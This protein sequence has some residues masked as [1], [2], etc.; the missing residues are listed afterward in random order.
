VKRE[1]LV[2]TA[3]IMVSLALGTGCQKK[4]TSPVQQVDQPA[5]LGDVTPAPEGTTDMGTDVAV[6][7]PSTPSAMP[8]GTTG[9]GRIHV[10]QRGDTLFKLAR[11]YYN[12]QSQWKRIYEANR[13]QIPN[14]NVLKVGQKLIIP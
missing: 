6:T 11:Q 10:V 9:A 14:Q 4:T 5:K 8:S 12:D 1:W 3:A 2:A 7:P 13:T